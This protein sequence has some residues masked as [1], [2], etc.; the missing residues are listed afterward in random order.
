MSTSTWLPLLCPLG[1]AIAVAAAQAACDRVT[2]TGRGGSI[3]DTVE[4]VDWNDALDPNT[5]EVYLSQLLFWDSEPTR[6]DPGNLEVIGWRRIHTRGQVAVEHR[7][8]RVRVVFY[9]AQDAVLRE[10]FCSEYRRYYTW[11]DPELAERE[12]FPLEFRR[13]LTPAKLP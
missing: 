9:D 7:G 2:L 1:V 4:R 6:D 12:R 11:H 8:N 3:L 5:G 13:D 10:V